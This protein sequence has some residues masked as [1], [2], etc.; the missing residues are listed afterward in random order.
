MGDR[1]ITAGDAAWIVALASGGA[2]DVMDVVMTNQARLRTV[3]FSAAATAQQLYDE[4]V[5]RWLDYVARVVENNPTRDF[6]EIVGRSDVRGLLEEVVA[7]AAA[8][9]EQSVRDAWQVGAELGLAHVL[10]ELRALGLPVPDVDDIVAQTLQSGYLASVLDDMTRRANEAVGRV[11]AAAQAAFDSI[12]IDISDGGVVN[13]RQRLAF[14][15]A[16][17]IR[18]GVKAEA[19]RLGRSAAAAASVTTNRGYSESQIEAYARAQTELN[20]AGG[21]GRII[22]KLWVTAFRPTTCGTCAALHGTVVDI[23]VEFPHGQSYEARP[24]RVYSNLQAPPRHPNCGCRLVPFV[25]GE[26]GEVDPTAMREFGRQWVESNG[27][28]IVPALL[29][30]QALGAEPPPEETPT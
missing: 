23:Y 20:A 19:A 7:V 13:T 10:I 8:G 25:D 24:P 16:Q 30:D 11:L 14:Q 12:E 22:R 21:R 6:A 4:A 2:G 26:F 15:R 1:E 27:S 29:F 18:A 5:T 17:A 9:V 3:E 28:G